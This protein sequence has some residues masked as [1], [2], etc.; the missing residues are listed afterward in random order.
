MALTPFPYITRVGW[1]VCIVPRPLDDAPGKLLG[2]A[3]WLG[4]GSPGP[5]VVL[6]TKQGFR[7]S[8]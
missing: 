2:L 4:H 6:S 7:L 8:T 5:T 1:A 3:V